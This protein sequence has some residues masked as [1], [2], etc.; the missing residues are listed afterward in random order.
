MATRPTS[1]SRSPTPTPPPFAGT[2][3]TATRER[4]LVQVRGD[5]SLLIA[6]HAMLAGRRALAG[7]TGAP[8]TERAN[9]RSAPGGSDDFVQ[10]ASLM[11]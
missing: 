1:S 9:E 3:D 10:E 6:S 4:G 8:A 2:L 11:S 5:L 7:L